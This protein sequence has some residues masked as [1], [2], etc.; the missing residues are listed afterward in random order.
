MLG[1]EGQ[2]LAVAVA[3]CQRTTLSPEPLE[4]KR[5]VV[6]GSLDAARDG[7]GIAETIKSV[8]P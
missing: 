7:R 3:S 1:N 4:L 8:L 6:P 5:K 2:E